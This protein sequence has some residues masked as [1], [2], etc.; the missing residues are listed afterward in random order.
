MKKLKI[1]SLLIVLLCMTGLTASA[2]DIEVKNGDGVTIYYNYINNKTELSVTYRGNFP[3]SY[4]NEYTGNVVIPESVIYNSNIYRVTSI[5][6]YAFC[7]CTGLTSITIPNSVTRIGKS[8]FSSCLGLTSITIPN[9]VTTIG[10]SA[11]ENCTG[12]TKVITEDLDAWCKISFGNASAN[13]LCYAHHLYNIDDTEI[14]DVTI[15]SEMTSVGA[16]QFYGSEGLKS[17]SIPKNVASIGTSAFDGC[18]A[19]TSVTMDSNEIMSKNYSE[20]N[21]LKNIFGAQVTD[22]KIGENVTNIGDYAFYGCERITSMIIPKGITSVGG[23]AFSGC[24]GITSLSFYCPNV[25]SWFAG[26]SSVKEVII[27]EGVTSIGNYAFN[28][29]NGIENISISNSVTSIGDF[30]FKGCTGLTSITI[31]NS[32]TS[33][34]GSA[35][36]DCSG[37]T[38][39]SIGNSV[40]S[41]KNYAFYNTYLKSVTIGSG[42]LSIE[43]KTF[44]YDNT[45]GANPIKV[46]WLTN[47]PPTG[48]SNVKASAHYVANDLY[49]GLSNKTVYPF[50]SS[51]F[52]VG[53]IKYVPVSPSERTCDAIDCT[54]D[55]TNENINIGESV[56]FKGVN[57]KVSQVHPFAFYENDKIKD[58]KLSFNGNIGD[59]AF[60]GCI[61]IKTA[62]VSNNG[63]IGNYAFYDCTGITSATISN[64]G[65]IG[66]SAFYNCTKMR[67]AELGSNITS[68]GSSAF[69]YCSSLQSID[70]P[71]AVKT[72]G[73]SAFS[74]C[75][76]MIS[77]KTG[78]GIEL[79]N[80]ST[81]SGCKSLTDVTI[82][83]GVKT[84][85]GSN[86]DG[87]FNYCSALAK[88]KIPKNVK[89][90]RDY[91]FKGCTSLKKVTMEDSEDE[92]SLASNDSSPLFADCP[93]D[94]VYIG[95]NIS[96]N[97]TSSKGYSPFY[98]NTS[99]RSVT[100][101][102]KETEI[103]E[104]EFYG[105][106]NLK[107]VKIGDGVTNI[108]NWAFSG[109]SSLDYFSFGSAVSEIG[110]EA[111]S[112]CTAM[113]KLITKAMTP[114]NCLSQ[115]LDDI[116]KWNCTLHVP[117]GTT[118]LYQQ[119][120]QWK[121]F[122]FI[123]DD[124]PTA[125]NDVN[126]NENMNHKVKSIFTID[127]KPLAKPQKGMN[128]LKIS[129]GTVRK[130]VVQ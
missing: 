69:S 21:S 91:V 6:S 117:K 109:C 40:T 82:G 92:L 43:D 120:A 76:S 101:T 64:Q 89:A 57:M 98:R 118:P 75:K 90:I 84:I 18:T 73:S 42:V 80:T 44:S 17:I 12:L 65:S 1:T 79:L 127:G 55:E 102:D 74:G 7:E 121:E 70:V 48:Y 9:R 50:L 123:D 5:G 106:T 8:A 95:R 93:L 72:L 107:E 11:F 122:F 45:K 34:G 10:G 38:S 67:T 125:I 111:F 58:V 103:S 22:Y 3:S 54:Y 36:Y 108:G 27:G 116:N 96:Y 31:P 113:T 105:C 26:N 39:V 14:T 59:Y 124:A 130:I 4:S 32:V 2:Q 51:M 30:A 100:I 81:F 112:D 15:P 77:A 94:E 83:T 47:T 49:T 114:P 16:Y 71:D 24:S 99:L 19:L 23:N 33:I 35:F 62:D 126:G 97:K 104:N 119:A 63:D 56:S 41:I 29:C 78:N 52:E 66:N 110:Q 13:P 86:Y 46:I 60:S 115:A 28:M 37:L 129:D 87:C 20:N 85:Y 128:I 68:I 25:G 88:I 61:G 53:G